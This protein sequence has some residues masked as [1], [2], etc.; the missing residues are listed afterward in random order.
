MGS[1]TPVLKTGN[2]VFNQFVIEWLGTDVD[3]SKIKDDNKGFVRFGKD[4][5]LKVTNLY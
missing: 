3:F 5:V 2:T 4:K 1:I